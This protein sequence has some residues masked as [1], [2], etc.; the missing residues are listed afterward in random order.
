MPEPAG[1]EVLVRVQA[2]GLCGSDLH[3]WGEVMYGPSIVMGH[4]IAG[5]VVA[6]GAGVEQVPQGDADRLLEL[7]QPGG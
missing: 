4:E 1:G 2:K 5:E 6:L 3:T 7:V